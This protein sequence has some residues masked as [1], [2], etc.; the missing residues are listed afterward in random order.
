VASIRIKIAIIWIFF[1][2]SDSFGGLP[3]TSTI[4][5]PNDAKRAITSNGLN[6]SANIKKA[7]TATTSGAVFQMRLVSAKVSYCTA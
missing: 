2:K 5:P 4:I 1:Y 7:N 3:Y 6:L